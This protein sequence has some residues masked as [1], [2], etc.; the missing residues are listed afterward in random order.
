MGQRQIKGYE[1]N[2]ARTK[3]IERELG[4]VI[5]ILVY[6]MATQIQIA[7]LIYEGPLTSWLAHFLGSAVAA[8]AEAYESRSIFRMRSRAVRLPGSC[9]NLHF[10]AGEKSSP[11]VCEGWKRT[12]R[13]LWE[14]ARLCTAFFAET[15]IAMDGRFRRLLTFQKTS[16]LTSNFSHKMIK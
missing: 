5:F 3:Q 1:T 9:A 16:V 8:A 11:F 7:N 12:S 6:A 14:R 4:R 13:A 15:C 10:S 2:A